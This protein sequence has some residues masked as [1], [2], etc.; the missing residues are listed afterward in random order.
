MDSM[1]M[2]SAV[3][4]AIIIRTEKPLRLFQ[5]VELRSVLL[6]LERFFA[7]GDV[8]LH[9]MLDPD[10]LDYGSV[11]MARPSDVVSLSE[12]GELTLSITWCG[13]PSDVELLHMAR[14]LQCLTVDGGRLLICRADAPSSP[15]ASV[16]LDAMDRVY[17][18]WKWTAGFR[19]RHE[20]GLNALA[21]QHLRTALHG[22]RSARPMLAF[23]RCAA[24]LRGAAGR[25]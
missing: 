13:K 15:L 10:D 11:P 21:N 19:L 20:A 16:S 8:E 3:L 22:S 24:Y 1:P 2:L 6:A 14:A 17:V 12:A 9:G 18:K 25:R 23:Q 7:L 5:S 4:T